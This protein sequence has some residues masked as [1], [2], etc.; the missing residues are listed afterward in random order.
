YY[1]KKLKAEQILSIKD[2]PL[3]F[4]YAKNDRSVSPGVY[5]K[6]LLKLLEKAG[7]ENVIVS[8]FDDVHDTSGLFEKDGKPYNYFGHFSWIYFFNN[9]CVDKNVS[10]WEWIA[11]RSR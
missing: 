5:T 6:P 4:I 7:A 3:W 1:P 9:E 11:Q 10:I 8:E 2:L